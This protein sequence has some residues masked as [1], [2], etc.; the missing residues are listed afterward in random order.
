MSAILSAV[1]CSTVAD[2]IGNALYE[3]F[4]RIAICGFSVISV[5]GIMFFDSRQMSDMLKYASRL[6]QA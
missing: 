5:F 1:L 6:M 3:I 4:A 2:G